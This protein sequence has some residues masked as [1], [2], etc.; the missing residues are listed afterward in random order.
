MTILKVLKRPGAGDNSKADVF[1]WD[2]LTKLCYKI[3]QKANIRS[4]NSNSSLNIHNSMS[5]D[6]MRTQATKLLIQYTTLTDQYKRQGD[7]VF[8]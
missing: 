8:F 4:S 5:G 1:H 7:N 2:L 3:F 6:K